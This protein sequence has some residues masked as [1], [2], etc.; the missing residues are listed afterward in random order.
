MALTPE[1]IRKLKGEFAGLASAKTVTARPQSAADV[2][3]V[4]ETLATDIGI[5]VAFEIR[6]MSAGT[7]EK[8]AK[9]FKFDLNAS[10]HD[11][12]LAFSKVLRASK[13]TE[14]VSGGK[15]LVLMNEPQ[16]GHQPSKWAVMILS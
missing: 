5:Q 1:Q 3:F 10:K 9:R 2:K 8:I 16:S 13:E 15:K 14:V 7:R 4:I 11:V 12:S 6:G